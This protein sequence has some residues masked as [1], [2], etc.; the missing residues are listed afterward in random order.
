MTLPGSYDLYAYIPDNY[1]DAI[2]ARYHIETSYGSTM[3]VIDQS[4]YANEWVQLG[5]FWFYPGCASVLLGDATGVQGQYIAFDA[6]KWEYQ[7]PGIEE[8]ETSP[9]RTKVALAK[10][11]VRKLIELNISGGSGMELAISLYDIT[12]RCLYEKHEILNCDI[13]EIECDVGCLP[14]GVYVLRTSIDRRDTFNKCI[15]VK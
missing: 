12:G 15:I 7:G 3:V 10:N 4:S 14:A 2:G 8:S 1:A 5:N 13:Q 6:M 9:F 11:P